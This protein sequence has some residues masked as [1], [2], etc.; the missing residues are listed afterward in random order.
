[1]IKLE[2]ASK[3]LLDFHNHST[4]SD[5]SDT[6]YQLVE[7]AKN[8]G[9]TAMALTDHHGIGGLPEFV[10]ACEKLGVFGIPF[11]MEISAEL[12]KKVLTPQDMSSPDLVVLGKNPYLEPIQGYQEIYFNDLEH[13]HLPEVLAGLESVGFEI[14]SVDLKEQVA[15]F[16][17]PPEILH[18]FVYHKENMQVLV[19]Y[20]QGIDPSITETEIKEKP[21]RFANRYLYA[22]GMPAYASRFEGFDFSDAV[23]LAEEM[24]CGLFIAHPGGEYGFLTDAMLNYMINEGVQ[25]IEVRNYFNSPEQNAKFDSLAK[26]FDLIKSGGSDCHGEKGPFKIGCYDRLQN[27]IPKEVLEELWDNLLN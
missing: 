13:R 11:G 18:D 12:P 5:G 6:P 4:Y 15:S 21:V 8:R 3:G 16:H 17:I 20:V 1:M 9:V 25:G 2:Y 26:G 10:D 7:R 27:Q 23:G 22:V 24:N 19:D 14:P